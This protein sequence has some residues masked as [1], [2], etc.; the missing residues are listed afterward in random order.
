MSSCSQ[1]IDQ[2]MLSFFSA[3]SVL[4]RKMSTR[5]SREELIKKGVLKEVYEKGEI[6]RKS[7]HF[8]AL[9][10][11]NANGISV[12]VCDFICYSLSV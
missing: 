6:R 4:E 2:R 9:K 12:F 10:L 5:Q 11:V 1:G 3:F 8:T 7:S